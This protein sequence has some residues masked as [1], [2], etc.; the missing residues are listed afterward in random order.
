MLKFVTLYVWL[1]FF[2]GVASRTAPYTKND[3]KTL[4]VNLARGHI[5]LNDMF[6]EVEKLMED[7]QHKLEEAVQ[8][9]TKREPLRM[10]NSEH[11]QSVSLKSNQM[12]YIGRSNMSLTFTFW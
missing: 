6:R 10:A 3:M 2:N 1:H 12:Y 11:F 9:V 5:T 4:D 8:Q 7:T